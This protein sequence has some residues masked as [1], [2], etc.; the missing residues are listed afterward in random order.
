[1]SAVKK[2]FRVVDF[3]SEW[4]GKICFPLILLLGAV[5][6]LEITMRLLFKATLWTFETTQFIF[7]ICSLL[8][9]GLLQKE[10]S[11]IVV[12][13]IYIRLSEKTKLILDI[14]TFP[15]FLLFVGGMVYF[16]GSFAYESVLS[17]ETTGSAWDPPVY[18]IKVIL[19]L[20]ALLLFLQ[21]IVN[22]VRNIEKFRSHKS[23][24]T[25]EASA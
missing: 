22:L 24:Q 8:P 20:S 19:P 2:I 25:N 17:L 1:M 7:A 10:R 11:H 18:P 15:F 23:G 21:G 12:D 9:A 6:L 16:G 3:L 5:V 13:V 14:I 4:S